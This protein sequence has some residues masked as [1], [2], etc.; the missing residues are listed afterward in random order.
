MKN[1]LLLLALASFSA[2]LFG[3]SVSDAVRYANLQPGGSARFMGAGGAFGALGADFG[4]LSVNPAGLAMY[5]TNELVFTP[6]L[7][8]AQSATA[9]EGAGNARFNDDVSSF[10]FANVGLV[11]NTSPRY[12][13]WTTFNFGLGLNRQQ[14]FQQSIYYE[15]WG[16][17]T[18]LNGWYNETDQVLNG[19]GKVEDL[20]AH[21]ARLGVDANAIYLQNGVWSYD[22]IN[23]PQ[24]DIRRVQS[25][26]SSGGVQEMVF[27][28]AGNYDERVLIGATVGVPFVNYR[29]EGSY[30]ESDP[31]QNVEYFDNLVFTEYLR[32]QGVGVNL[33][34]GV[35]LRLTQSLRLGGAFHTPTLMGLTDN[36]SNTF[37]YDYTDNSGSNSK[38]AESPEGV[39][40]YR[41][42]TPWRA[43][44]S[45]AFLVQQYGFLSADLEWVDYGANRYNFT[46]DI[47]STENEQL[48]RAINSEIQRNLQQT[49]N[50]RLGAEA[51][52]NVFRLRAG[53]NLLGK[54]YEG[55]TGFN[56]A[57]TGG[58]GLRFESF[59]LDLGFRRNT[60]S[61]GVQ[62]Y[63]DAPVANADLRS[64]EWVMTVGFKF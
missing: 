5:R 10:G 37:S 57:I 61:A 30:E 24:A 54:P 27:S 6:A 8:F 49:M 16:N 25:L 42:R 3:Q 26:L 62:T 41:L 4:V 39:F 22:F 52:I 23:N 7:K 31:D 2:S 51:A 58:A 29:L 12:S 9:L 1:K 21:G 48:E 40:D 32:T 45:A 43:I 35:V 38:L 64:S 55:Q 44:A 63:P 59:Y 33:K 19:G 53:L 36:F 15:G 34:M 20:Y 56:T 11:F 17:G 50:V 46:S 18:I 47:A 28:F 14:N 13:K 60:G